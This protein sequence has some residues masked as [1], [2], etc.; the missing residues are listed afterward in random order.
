L[1]AK[2]L[3]GFDDV[4]KLPDLDGFSE[5]FAPESYSD[6]EDDSVGTSVSAVP[7]G[8]IAVSSSAAAGGT[9]D[10]KEMVSAIQTMLKR[11]QKG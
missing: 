3:G 11:D 10:T 2:P 4:D 8:D 5:S 6:G 7:A 1:Y 9:F